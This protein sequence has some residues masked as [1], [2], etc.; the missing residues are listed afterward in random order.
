MT[1]ITSVPTMMAM[2]VSETQVLSH[3]QTAQVK[4]IRMGDPTPATQ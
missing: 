1:W 3:I 2:V 4:F